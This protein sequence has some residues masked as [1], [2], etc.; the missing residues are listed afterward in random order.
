MFSCSYDGTIKMTE[1]TQNSSKTL[2]KTNTKIYDLDIK[3]NNEDNIISLI[4][5][6]DY[7]YY[8]LKSFSFKKLLEKFYQK[9]STGLLFYCD[10]NI[11][12]NKSYDNW[13]N[14]PFNDKLCMGRST[15]ISWGE[16]D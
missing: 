12:N 5:T 10:V 15:I 4:A 2:L 7:G 11:K 6:T 9:N 16:S 1:L 8:T 3:L 13:S 14:C